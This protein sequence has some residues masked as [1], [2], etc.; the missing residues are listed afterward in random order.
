MKDWT[1]V[2]SRDWTGN[3]GVGLLRPKKVRADS[4][5]RVI[6]HGVRV[7][8]TF[9]PVGR[10]CRD[11]GN[12]FLGGV[13]VVS[14]VRLTFLG[15]GVIPDRTPVDLRPDVGLLLHPSVLSQTSD[16]LTRQRTKVITTPSIC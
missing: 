12:V 9:R 5:V 3:G 10:G 13:G 4:D 15:S 11:G 14:G 2:E 16:L 6:R 7:G 8:V 1:K